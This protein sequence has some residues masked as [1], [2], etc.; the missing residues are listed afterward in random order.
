MACG[1][2]GGGGR[3]G[4]GSAGVDVVEDDQGLGGLT[5]EIWA[6]AKG[7]LKV[8]A[9][10]LGG[11]GKLG[12]GGALADEAPIEAGESCG[13]AEGLAD[14]V[15]LVEAALGEFVGVEGDGDEPGRSMG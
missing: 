5:M 6:D 4:C 7:I 15:D 2:E 9:A 3:S 14:E 10:G 12:L 13:L 1:F 11:E 8:L